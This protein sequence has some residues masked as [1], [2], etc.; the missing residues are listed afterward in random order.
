MNLINKRILIT[1]GPTWVPIDKVRIISNIATGKTG[2]LLAKK[3][4]NLGSQVTLL[5][6]QIGDLKNL[7]KDIRIIRFSF[8]H[9]LRNIMVKEL[10]SK[11]YDIVIHS[12]AVSDY[13]PKITHP[14]KVKSGK[15]I[16]KINLIPTEKLIERVKKINKDI[17]LVGFKFD[18][19]VDKNKL[20]KKA[21]VLMQDAY[22]DL[23]VANTLKNNKYQAY[24]LNQ[25][26]IYGPLYQ[27]ESLVNKL[28]KLMKKTYKHEFTRIKSR[29]ITNNLCKFDKNS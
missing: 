6:G 18:L 20:I 12:A 16:W 5:L 3:L 19:N 25:K 15:S 29:I 14:Y 9:E 10:R 24:I 27:K 4:R 21:K 23:A 7:P 1:A 2:I 28:I 22:L 11:K 13:Q 17:F 8:F 26:K